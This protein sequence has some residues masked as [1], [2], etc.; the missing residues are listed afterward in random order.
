M[1]SRRLKYLIKSK[2]FRFVKDLKDK[3]HYI[4]SFIWKNKKLYYRS[5][6]SDMT[7]IY[8][9]LLQTKYKSEYYLPE[10]LS[11]KIVFKTTKVREEN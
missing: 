9:I 3:S 7:L 2:S 8:E 10:K 11:P 5:S 6:T 1:S 4:S